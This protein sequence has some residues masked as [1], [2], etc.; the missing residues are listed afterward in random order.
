MTPEFW[1]ALAPYVAVIRSNQTT[2]QQKQEAITACYALA[3]DKA[4]ECL[5]DL[6]LLLTTLEGMTGH[7]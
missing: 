4:P 1:G 7:G 5:P 2:P 6:W 3:H